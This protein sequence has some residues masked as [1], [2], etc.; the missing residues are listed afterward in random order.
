LFASE[1]MNLSLKELPQTAA[2]TGSGIFC[3]VRTTQGRT[4]CAAN[5]ESDQRA[6]M[7]EQWVRFA[8]A[9]GKQIWYKLGIQNSNLLLAASQPD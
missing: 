8:N 3:S 2:P 6:G 4:S 1:R 7:R 9:Q 5:G